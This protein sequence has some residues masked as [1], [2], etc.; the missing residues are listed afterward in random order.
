[1]NIEWDQRKNLANQ[2][3]H[4]LCFEDA[5]TVFAGRTVV[6]LDQRR[7]YGETRYNA[8]GMLEGLVVFVSFTARGEALRI[9]SM[10][11]ANR[12]ERS[13]YESHQE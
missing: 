13:V 4:G 3:K 8:V 11:P 7:E 2:A 6:A 12:K 10:R 1:M 5:A 9:I